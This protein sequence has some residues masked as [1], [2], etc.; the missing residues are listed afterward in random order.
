MFSKQ[1]SQ[2]NLQRILHILSPHWPQMQPSNYR[3]LQYEFLGDYSWL[4]CKRGHYYILICMG[5]QLAVNS[6]LMSK[7]T[8]LSHTQNIYNIFVQCGVF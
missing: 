1:I 7:K 2:I 3:P 6:S 4:S 8:Q 5:F